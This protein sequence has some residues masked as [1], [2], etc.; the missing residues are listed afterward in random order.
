MGEIA[1]T[2]RLLLSGFGAAAFAGQARAE[3]RLI[4]AA[5]LRA[6]LAAVVPT[7]RR[8]HPD[9]SFTASV[10]QLDA[11]ATQLAA[12]LD[13]PM[14][15]REA[16]RVMA[17]LNPLFG[18]AHTGLR[19]PVNEFEAHRSAGGAVFPAPVAIDREGRL[20][21]SATVP[22]GHA[23]APLEIIE[24]INGVPAS[25]VLAELMPLMRGETLSLRRFVLTVNFPALLWTVRGPEPRY[26][27][28]VRGQD[29][30]I[31][32]MQGIQPPPA[33]QLLE[34]FR[35]SWPT[36]DT[37]LLRVATFDP[38]LKAQFAT[39]LDQA[40]AEILARSARTLLIDVRDNPGG[41]H[42]LSDQLVARLT[43]RPVSPASTLV[44]R[45]TADNRDIKP[46]AQLGTVVTTRF[47]EPIAP[48]P[49]DRRFGGRTYVLVSQDTYSQAIVFS[50]TLKDHGLAT[51]VGE[52]TGGNANQTG[53]ITLN[54]LPRT[55][56]QVLAPLYIIY[57]PS[58]DRQAA[59]LQ[60]DIALPHDPMQP[61]VMIGALLGRRI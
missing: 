3:G 49:P 4:P 48:A 60:P 55:G 6:D 53:Q 54:P 19:H 20:R 51:V 57:R 39:F 28:G 61:D 44:G 1:P 29:G 5:D 34:P 8:I 7:V 18:D 45:I 12:R 26:D 31:R 15:V 13:R 59:G 42:D 11:H 2:R 27:L 36:P 16:W 30:R 23:L 43:D 17:R 9:L 40:F 41:A 21:V 37:A 52:V 50:V 10:P 58:G 14:T 22:E 56:L 33:A 24:T 35:L 25:R 46:D 38:A 32:T 47:D